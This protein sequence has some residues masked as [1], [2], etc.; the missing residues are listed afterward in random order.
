MIAHAGNIFKVFSNASSTSSI[1]SFYFLSL[2]RLFK[3]RF[4]IV[5]NKTFFTFDLF[6]N[7]ILNEN[8]IGSCKL[9]SIV[10]SETKSALNCRK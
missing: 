3:D 8:K 10:L 6:D 2:S 5:E 4:K 1:N 9:C 7:K